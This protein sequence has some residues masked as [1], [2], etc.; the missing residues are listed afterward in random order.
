MVCSLSNILFCESLR[1]C[2]SG[3]PVWVLILLVIVI[4]GIIAGVI[5]YK[6]CQ[7][8]RMGGAGKRKS[9]SNSDDSEKAEELQDLDKNKEFNSVEVEN[10]TAGDGSKIPLKSDT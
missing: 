4:V 6:A 10:S 9:R 1:I 2:I 7:S 8:R 5:I 3:F